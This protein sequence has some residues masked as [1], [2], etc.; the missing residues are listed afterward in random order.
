MRLVRYTVFP[1]QRLSQALTR[2]TRITCGSHCM[3]AR[4]VEFGNTCLRCS[5]QQWALW[6]SGSQPVSVVHSRGTSA[7]LVHSLLPASC[8]A[9]L[10]LLINPIGVEGP[11]RAGTP[12]LRKQGL[13]QQYSL[14]RSLACLPACLP[15]RMHAQ[16]R[17]AAPCHPNPQKIF[18]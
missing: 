9:D 1:H 14:P 11:P 15:A 17:S 8:A 7:P 16:S 12:E 13:R 6:P 4:P 18:G 5:Q 2:L 10:Q 3:H